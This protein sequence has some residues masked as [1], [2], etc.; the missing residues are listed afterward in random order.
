VRDFHHTELRQVFGQVL[1][2]QQREAALAQPPY[3]VR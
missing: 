3:Q 2:F 1:D